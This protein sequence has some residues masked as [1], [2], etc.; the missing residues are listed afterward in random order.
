MVHRNT[1]TCT[2]FISLLVIPTTSI[3]RLETWGDTLPIHSRLNCQKCNIHDQL[4]EALAK[5]AMDK[6]FD[7]QQL[8]KPGDTDLVAID[9]VFERC[10]NCRDRSEEGS[11]GVDNMSLVGMFSNFFQQ[12]S[13]NWEE[14]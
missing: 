4:H 2:A 13:M 5:L 7:F 12:M 10:H 14:A 8:R 11:F 6:A 3:Q 9:R 1:N